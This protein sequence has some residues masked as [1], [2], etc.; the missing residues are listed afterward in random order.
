MTCSINPTLPSLLA[1]HFVQP[2]HTE[3]K[4][5]RTSDVFA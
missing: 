5:G 2:N 3:N 1:K 4:E